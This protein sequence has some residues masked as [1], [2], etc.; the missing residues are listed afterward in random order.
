MNFQESVP[1]AVVLVNYK[2]PH[3]TRRCLRALEKQSVQP[4]QV[5]VIDNAS[6]KKSQDFF[7][8][9][10]FSFPIQFIFNEENLGFAAGCNQ[11][12]LAAKKARDEHFIWLL[13][14]DTIPEKNALKE[15]YNHAIMTKAGITG[16]AIYDNHGKF[17]GGA[18]TIHKRFASVHRIAT[19]DEKSFDYIEGSSFL[20]SPNCLR[21]IGLFSEDYFLY[22][23]ESDYCKRAQNAGLTL[24]FAPQS[25]IV[26]EIGSSTGSERGKGRTPYF[27]DCLMLRNR[28]HFA[29]KF[30][31]NR[32]GIYTG[33]FISFILRF[34]RLQWIRIFT[35]SCLIFSKSYF[36]KFVKKNGGFI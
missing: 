35:V 24:A 30:Q 11:G 16:S 12:M 29:R 26:H 25:H 13:N 21:A 14:N 9:E 3:Q 17:I 19:P 18:G 22:F 28:I 8:N 5:F 7:N 2:L 34:K 20:I 31:F 6:S 33:L 36:Q 32:I 23:E 4:R 1:V 15:I 27:I 10:T